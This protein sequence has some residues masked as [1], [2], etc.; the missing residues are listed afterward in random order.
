MEIKVLGP[1]CARCKAVEQNVLNALAEMGIKAEVEEVTDL[2]KIA[3]YGI[4]VTPGLVI[5]DKV[6]AFGR[7]P[8]QIEIKK[9]LQEEMYI[10]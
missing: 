7:I 10:P 6:K 5:N 9:W 4:M 3:D 1:G 8:D 2:N